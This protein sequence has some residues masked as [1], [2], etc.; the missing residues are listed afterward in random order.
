MSLPICETFALDEV[1][2]D[3]CSELQ[4][5]EFERHVATCDHCQRQLERLAAEDRWWTT[6][7]GHLSTISEVQLP[8]SVQSQLVRSGSFVIPS[9]DES[10]ATA[11]PSNA[12]GGIAAST[13]EWTRILDPPDHPEVLGK[14]D[15]FEIE[16]RLGQGGMGI[17]LKGYDRSLNRPVAIKVLSPHLA[18]N[19]TSRKRFAREAQAAAAVVHPNVI[20]IYA[21]HDS[22]TRPYIVMQL[23]SGHSLQTWVQE[24]GPLNVK[25]I[26]RVG[27][28]VADG[29]EAAH[30]QGLIHRDIKPANVLTEQDVSRVVITDF[31]LARAADDAGIT[32]TGWIAGTPHYMSPEQ[33]RGVGLDCRSDLFSLGSL[34]YFLAT[35]REPFRSDSPYGVIQKIIHENPACPLELNN[36][37]PP[38]V[39][40]IIQKLLEKDPGDRFNTASELKDLLKRYLAHLQQ[41]AKVAR[42]AR[43]LTRRRRKFR[44]S[45]YA[46]MT[47]V[48][49]LGCFL[50]A[51][52]AGWFGN[53]PEPNKPATP[54]DSARVP[55][56]SRSGE[57][58]TGFS[59]FFRDEEFQREFYEIETELDS[60]QQ[61]LEQ[62]SP[63]EFPIAPANLPGGLDQFIEQVETYQ[64][65]ESQQTKELKQ[66]L[67]RSRKP[68]FNSNPTE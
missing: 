43:L 39:S 2:Q 12:S 26:V 54:G 45:V 22:P 42:P 15:Q 16:S 49:G 41:P 11:S 47:V 5:K 36:D 68:N 58:P 60:L 67:E 51:T 18:C 14:I 32:Q 19:G 37:L 13:M 23:V 9:V 1:L 3:D 4:Q 34:L 55:M 29:L 59:G 35:G 48:A 6:A 17:V 65:S 24:N 50:L 27:I 63:I 64:H 25:D 31:G 38:L 57:S 21:V 46:G 33:A 7:T 40:D 28:Q 30:Q 62:T 61:S 20:P 52:S 53:L 66:L 44:R 8:E 56:H 10:L